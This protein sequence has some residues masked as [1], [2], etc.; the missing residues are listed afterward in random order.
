MKHK[1]DHT[2]IIRTRGRTFWL[3]LALS[4]YSSHNYKG[5]IHVEDDSLDKDFCENKVNIQHFKKTLNIKH[6]HGGG[7]KEKTRSRRVLVTTINSLKRIKTEFYSFSSDDDFLFPDFVTHGIDF[8]RKN[9]E[10][11][12]VTGSEIKIHYDGD[13]RVDKTIIRSWSGSE[14]DDPLDRIFDY[15]TNPTLSYYGICRTSMRNY[16]DQVTKKTG[17]ECFGREGVVDFPSYDEEYPWVLLV[18]CAG[19]IRYY[20]DNVMNMRGIYDSPDRV[21]NMHLGDISS[22]YSLGTIFTLM[23]STAYRGIR[24]SHEDICELVHFCGTQ[25]DKDVVSNSVMRI[26]W[27]FLRQRVGNGLLH[28]STEFGNKDTSK[29]NVISGIPYIRNFIKFFYYKVI[30][31]IRYI[32]VLPQLKLFIASHNTFLKN[33]RYKYEARLLQQNFDFYNNAKKK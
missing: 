15:A 18:Y 23:D 8:L 21:E 1:L 11:S 14:Y 12:C 33:N 9:K 17:R 25:Y 4:H 10:Y 3:N 7:Y 6:F 28:P 13:F 22:V 32:K 19:K 5:V 27:F 16:L 29:K 26:L 31:L 30:K 20:P 2:L 24:E